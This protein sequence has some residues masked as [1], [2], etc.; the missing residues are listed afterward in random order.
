VMFPNSN[1]IVKNKRNDGLRNLN[2]EF[3][4]DV[5]QFKLKKNDN[6]SFLNFL[7]NTKKWFLYLKTSFTLIFAKGW[8]SY[9]HL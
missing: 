9:V 5:G 8:L 2:F 6:F 1:L 3:L 4:A 7:S